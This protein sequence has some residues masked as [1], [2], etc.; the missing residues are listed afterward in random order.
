[1][2][3]ITEKSALKSLTYALHQAMKSK[4][5][6]KISEFREVF[7]Q[8]LGAKDW[9][10][11]L[12]QFDEVTTPNQLSDHNIEISLQDPC[13]DYDST[14]HGILN[15]KTALAIINLFFQSE[16]WLLAPFGGNIFENKES[17]IAFVNAN[18]SYPLSVVMMTNNSQGSISA[19]LNNLEDCRDIALRNED[20]LTLIP[21][22][23]FKSI[24]DI[25][26]RLADFMTVI[27]KYEHND[28]SSYCYPFITKG[29]KYVSYINDFDYNESEHGEL[30]KN[31]G[32]FFIDFVYKHKAFQI[33]MPDGQ[34]FDSKQEAFEFRNLFPNHPVTL[35]VDLGYY[36]LEKTG[37]GCAFDVINIGS[38]IQL[39]ERS[40]FTA[41]NVTIPSRCDDNFAIKRISALIKRTNDITETQFKTDESLIESFMSA[42][43]NPESFTYLCSKILNK[44]LTH[45][46]TYYLCEYGS[47]YEQQD[48]RKIVL[49]TIDNLSR[50]EKNALVIDHNL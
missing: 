12:G 50:E 39:I 23:R 48:I 38:D 5:N 2:I 43:T 27:A 31:I 30:D 36:D 42:Y 45:K 28:T 26:D 47:V 15:K 34:P 35:I 41:H 7:S 6:M 46:G 32:N 10:A 21:Q 1:M 13:S 49:H 8:Q 4:P 29:H 20:Y 22:G 25:E 24:N 9:N 19:I 44:N 17:A 3:N 37:M 16:F 33:G 40:E 14:T 18:P 11:L